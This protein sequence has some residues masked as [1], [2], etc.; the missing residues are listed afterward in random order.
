MSWKLLGLT[1]C[2]LG[3]LALLRLV[4]LWRYQQSVHDVLLQRD[5]LEMWETSGSDGLDIRRSLRQAFYARHSIEAAAN[6]I[7][8]ILRR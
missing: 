7:L 1:L 6:E 3:C 2:A 4:L 8:W 5:G